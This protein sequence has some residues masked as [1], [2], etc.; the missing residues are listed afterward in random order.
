MSNIT[1]QLPPIDAWVASSLMQKAIR[2]GDAVFAREAAL[3]FYRMRGAAIWRRLT[4]IAHED[5]G[6]GDLS[7]CA[8]V[9]VCSIDKSVRQSLGSDRD[10]IVALVDRLC[11]APKN[12][13]TDYLICSV[14]QAPFTERLRSVVASRT[15][16]EHIRMAADPQM[17]LLDRAMAVWMA[18]GVNGGG[19]QVLSKGDMQNL[20]RAF[21]EAGLSSSVASTIL[22]ATNKTR[23]PIVMMVPLLSVALRQSQE[24]LTIV[25]DPLPSSVLC[26]GIPAYT[27]DKHT[28]LGKQAVRMLLSENAQVR[29][30]I[31]EFVPEFRAL[32]VA[33][34]AAFYAD[35]I[36]LGQ[37]ACWSQSEVLYQLGLRTDFMKIGIPEDGVLP[38]AE[39]MVSSLDHLNDIRR[40]LR[41]AIHKRGTRAVG[42]QE[43]AL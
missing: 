17:P 27:F 3:A 6:V 40:R 23:E 26:G 36:C 14:K 5:V 31:S 32:E 1:S 30:V 4:L 41:E 10:V 18:S 35:A 29:N 28:Q 34:M 24:R 37:R 16:L 33:N 2:R 15:T 7:L 11:L 13:E 12:R 39:E 25:H 9:T 8:H 19:P 22:A 43:F 38:I 20:I 21:E 42:Q